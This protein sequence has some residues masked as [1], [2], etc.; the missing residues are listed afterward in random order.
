VDGLNYRV[1]SR[2]FI[3]S[4]LS[5]SAIMAHLS[6]QSIIKRY[7]EDTRPG[8]LNLSCHIAGVSSWLSSHACNYGTFIGLIYRKEVLFDTLFGWFQ[9]SCHI[10]RIYLPRLQLRHLHFWC[11]YI[12]RVNCIQNFRTFYSSCLTQTLLQSLKRIS[13]FMTS[14]RITQRL[15]PFPSLILRAMRVERM[16]QGSSRVYFMIS[17]N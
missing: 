14:N 4:Y 17:Q 6:V 12:P 16:P 3:H 10:A 2:D 1:I 5:T 15:I 9:L 13:V 7:F 11:S 8:R